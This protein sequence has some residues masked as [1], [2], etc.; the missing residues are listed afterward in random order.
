YG[1]AFRGLK[2]CYRANGEA[3]GEVRLAEGLSPDDFQFHPALL[4]SCLQVAIAAL[5]ELRGAYLPVGIGRFRLHQRPGAT[6]WS[7]VRLRETS[8]G[9][10]AADIEILD[11][12]G[13]TVATIE[14]FRCRLV[15]S[16]SGSREPLDE[17]LYVSAW[18]ELPPA[19]TPPVEAAETWLV[20]ADDTGAAPALCERVEALGHRALLVFDGDPRASIEEALRDENPP[21]TNIIYL[22]ALDAEGPESTTLDTLAHDE[23][24]GSLTLLAIVQTLAKHAEENSPRLW[25]VTRRAQA[26]PC[27][28]HGMLSVSQSPLWGFRRV[29]AFEQ[30]RL[31]S[32]IVDI[33]SEAGEWELLAA[34]IQ[35]NGAEDE[36]ALRGSRRF[37]HRY[38]RSTL[39]RWT[40]GRVNRIAVSS[41]D[42]RAG[43]ERSGALDRLRLSA[44]PL[45]APGPHEVRVE[46]KAAALNFSDVLKALGLYPGVIA[47]TMALGAEG[48]G[49][50][51]E[52][53]SAVEGL[54][55]GD[56]V[57]AIAAHCLGSFVNTPYFYA[58]PIPES[59]TFEQAAGL[60]IVFATALHALEN[61]GR[62]QRGER[63]LI[64]AATGGVGLAAIQIAREIG[65]EIFATAGTPEKRDHL[66]SLGVRHVMDSRS[67]AFA[68]EVMAATNGEGVDLVLNSLSGEAI[69]RG[70]AVLRPFGRF[71]E[72]GKRDVHANALLGLRAMR[73]NITF[74]AFDLDQL[75]RIHPVLGARIFADVADGFSSGR[76]QPLPTNVFPLT[77]M[78]DAFR[79]LSK[80]QHIG[81]VVISNDV[82]EVDVVF[83]H[84]KMSVRPD[85]TYL[86]TGGVGGFAM[87][88]AAWLAGRGARHLVLVSRRGAAADGVAE[89]VELLAA[90]GATAHVWAADV[91]DETSLRSVLDRIAAELPPL[92]GIVHA[93]MV[94]EPGI[95]T[96]LDAARWTAVTK[97]K[98]TGSWN[99]HAQTLGL[100]LDFF[101]LTSSIASVYGS[102]G[103]A[104]YAAANAFLDALAHYRR[105]LGLP[106][107]T[108]NLGSLGGT[109]HVARDEKLG[110][111]LTQSGFP[112][113]PPAE[114]LDVLDRLLGSTAAQLGV[115]RMDIPR[116]AETLRQRMPLRLAALAELKIGAGDGRAGE[117][118]LRAALRAASPDEGGGLVLD[119]LARELGR[120]LGVDS[121]R[122]NVNQ[123]LMALGVDSLMTVEL[124]YWAEE[125]L[126]AKL[127]AVDVMQNPTIAELAGVLWSNLSKNQKTPSR[128]FVDDSRS[129]AKLD[130]G[131]IFFASDAAPL[132]SRTPFLTGAT[133]FLGASLLN[134]LLRDETTVVHCLVRAENANAGAARI[135]ENLSAYGLDVPNFERRV[136]PIPGDLAEPLLGLAPEGFSALAEA[137]DG[138]FHAGAT[139]DFL[140][141][142][143]VLRAVNVGGTHEILRLAAT[144]RS[145]RLHY[146][147]SIAVL[148]ATHHAGVIGE[149]VIPHTASDFPDGYSESKWTAEML[150][151]EAMQRGLKANIFRLGVISGHTETGGPNLSDASMLLLA[152]SCQAGVLPD[153]EWPI[154]VIP[155]DVVAR[156]ICHIAAREQSAST[157]HITSPQPTPSDQLAGWLLARELPL[158]RV[159]Y[160]RWLARMRKLAPQ[161]GFE[162]LLALLPDEQSHAARRMGAVD[163][164][165]EMA[166]TRSALAG[167]GIKL[168]ALTEA[169]FDVYLRHLAGRSLIVPH[170]ELQPA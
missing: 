145:K 147:S 111:Y 17:L 152:A 109:G 132:R 1:P 7:H 97:P 103:Q 149:D 98:I 44:V 4:D 45:D 83:A 113:T 63:V 168:Q 66:R 139:V 123:P 69:A 114:V 91:A 136:I 148:S 81:K 8:D 65:A 119:A 161:F 34:E 142:Y 62:L 38:E 96:S 35:A 51:T 84:E 99:L 9:A 134:E 156:A 22:R 105:G 146:I 23:D 128:T 159:P 121:D 86:I 108:L 54:K 6:V 164:R 72:I 26:L 58:R 43:S 106:A 138:I 102:P 56:R 133:G 60:P 126:G 80:A 157:F 11:P 67:L 79:Y 50:V 127:L 68:D 46:I 14:D 42:F 29:I 94:I 93:A 71:V 141:P 151:R 107:L 100:P 124:I 2:N 160:E 33:G 87:E 150:V 144:G 170:M 167:S 39:E 70:L 89:A 120:V 41:V 131:I 122:L 3:L 88:I 32:A 30:P 5:P 73:N 77:E 27:D 76:F 75:V 82:P 129:D 31:R 104:N 112:P 163:R 40:P 90:K 28:E 92:R 95:I 115:V 110:A 48:A 130:P 118:P 166:N 10:I 24:R 49:V 53:G 135:R 162:H 165:F 59:L 74:T 47:S 155:V 37:V 20:I 52:L 140:R 169:Q 101:V 36:I 154:D 78:V 57:M 153:F 64:H 25:I 15:E 16:E 143:D 137:V 125:A 61:I 55:V 12:E 13:A 19:E 158:E 18:P 117:H 116:I 85:A 21:L